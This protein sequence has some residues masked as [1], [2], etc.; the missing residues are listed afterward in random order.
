MYPLDFAKHPAGAFEF[1]ARELAPPSCFDHV[2]MTLP[3]KPNAS[4][5]HS[6]MPQQ[7]LF[8]I[9]LAWSARSCR[10]TCRC[11][12]DLFRRAAAAAAAAAATAASHAAASAATA[13]DDDEVIETFLDNR[14]LPYAS[15]GDSLPFHSVND[16]LDT[17]HTPCFAAIPQ[18]TM[19]RRP[20][21]TV[22]N[23]N[24]VA[25]QCQTMP[26]LR[27]AASAV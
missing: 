13:A 12:D 11:S 18:S 19:L 26:A 22:R 5:V 7:N 14:H 15:V 27:C 6:M 17:R 3:H 2:F 10:G 21:F 16:E 9:A 24:R 20:V 8:R 4:L 25:S 23:C 1:V